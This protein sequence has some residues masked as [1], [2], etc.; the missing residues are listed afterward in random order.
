LLAVP[1]K[2]GKGKVK[3]PDPILFSGDMPEKSGEVFGIAPVDERG[4]RG[5][6]WEKE[7][8]G[9]TEK[10]KEEDDDCLSLS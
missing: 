9:K 8:E 6:N 7:I 10:E 5:T 3:H 4:E 1:K 2:F